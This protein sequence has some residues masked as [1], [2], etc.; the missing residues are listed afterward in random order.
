MNDQERRAILGQQVASGQK[1]SEEAACDYR[2]GLWDT[3]REAC[4]NADGPSIRPAPTGPSE[5]VAVHNAEDACA[6]ATA[7]VTAQRGLP[8]THVAYCDQ[9]READS[10]SGFYIMALRAQCSDDL[11]GSTNMGWFA[12]QKATADIFEVDDVTDWKLGRR[13][14]DSN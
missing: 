1:T 14:T 3:E 12:V 7:L 10:P 4:F 2:L 5:Y 9:T 13:V 8:I 6:K 11:C